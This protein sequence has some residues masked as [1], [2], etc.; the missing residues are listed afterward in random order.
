MA[1]F[2]LSHIQKSN[3][4]RFLRQFSSRLRSESPLLFIDSKFVAGY[5]KPFSKT[6]AEGNTYQLRTLADGSQYE[7]TKN[8]LSK[9]EVV[10]ALS[11]FC[12][13]VE[14]VELDYL[15]SVK[16]VTK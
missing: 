7:I 2:W 1:H 4:P 10:S 5:R 12:Q 11:P 14:F 6:D 8:F 3:L 9:D 15:W 13:S 16:A